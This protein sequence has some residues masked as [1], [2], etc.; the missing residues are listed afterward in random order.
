M[1]PEGPPD[2]LVVNV[3]APRSYWS[4]DDDPPTEPSWEQR[5][6]EAQAAGAAAKSRL[7]GY[8]SPPAQRTCRL[9]SRVYVILRLA[10]GDICRPALRRASWAEVKPLVSAGERLGGLAVFQGF[11]SQREADAFEAAAFSP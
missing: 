4:D 7:R 1:N 8:R 6:S 9:R 11:P 2:P 10:N 5:L 3:D